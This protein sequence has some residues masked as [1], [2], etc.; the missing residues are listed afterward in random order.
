MPNLKPLSK[1]ITTQI[2]FILEGIKSGTLEHDQEYVH[3]GSAHCVAGWY[4]VIKA[5]ARGVKYDSS[6]DGFD[7]G[8]TEFDDALSLAQKDWRLTDD[9]RYILFSADATLTVQFALLKYLESGERVNDADYAYQNE[10]LVAVSQESLV[11]TPFIS[12]LQQQN[13]VQNNSC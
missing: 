2:R 1:K 9:E 8:P 6:K 10:T 12:Y 3:C 11:T 5:E 13:I 4:A 7:D